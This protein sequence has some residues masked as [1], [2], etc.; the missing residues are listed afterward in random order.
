L[1]FSRQKLPILDKDHYPIVEGV[2]RGAYILAESESGKPDILLLA[3]GSE[4]HLA[5][6]ARESLKKNGIGARVISMPS[7]EIFDEQSMEY[8]NEVLP[9]DIPKISIE[10]G[11]TLGWSKYIGSN[12]KAIGV[13]R[14]GAS[15]PGETVLD[16]LGFNVNNVMNQVLDLL[17]R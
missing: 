13:N 15:A 4:V 14:F 10:A 11:V 3:T 1:L 2:P 6:S 12:G 7:W 17:N 9:L 16:K 8:K 5:L